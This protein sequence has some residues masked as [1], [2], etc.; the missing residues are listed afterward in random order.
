MFDPNED[1]LAGQTPFLDAN[2]NGA[3]DLTSNQRASNAVQSFGSTGLISAPLK[4]SNLNGVIDGVNLSLNLT[5]SN[6]SELH[7]TLISPAGTRF[8]V[9]L[10]PD[11]NL[12]DQPIG[13]VRGE[14][15]NGVWRLQIIDDVPGSGG[16]LNNWSLDM[17]NGDITATSD[18]SGA[19]SFPH[20]EKGAYTLRN[21]TPNDFMRIT[22]ASGFYSVALAAGASI[23]RN[24]GYF[25]TRFFGT[26]GDDQ[27]TISLDST[28]T[29]LQIN[30]Y[31]IAKSL[32]TF[33]LGFDGA[34]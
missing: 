5:H 16:T 13:G 8:P 11:G 24:F 12:A 32:I 27:F 33:P 28:H 15:P 3:V 9:A 19:F 31:S 20:L 21:G 22:P 34:G 26:S 18:S 14:N 17:N 10:P 4:I 6:I 30:D 23:S 1:P 25:P 7:A 2:N 29:R